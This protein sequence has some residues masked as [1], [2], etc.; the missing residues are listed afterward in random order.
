MILQPEKL[1]QLSGLPHE[2]V[3]PETVQIASEA[4]KLGNSKQVVQKGSI[5]YVPGDLADFGGFLDQ[6]EVESI[7][8][9]KSES[10]IS[11]LP[12]SY[13]TKHGRNVHF[14]SFLT[15]AGRL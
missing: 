3:A 5:R 14:R 13:V 4:E 10:Y 12:G 6:V 9:E 2:P 7:L 8:M 1:D 11:R 15:R